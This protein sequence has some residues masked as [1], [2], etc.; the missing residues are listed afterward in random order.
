MDIGRAIDAESNPG[1][2]PRQ[3]D[4]PFIAEQEAIRLKTMRD[5]EPGRGMPGHPRYRVRVPGNRQD[6][7]LARVPRDI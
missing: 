1:P 7:R 4:R 2:E 5:D 3:E 6:Q